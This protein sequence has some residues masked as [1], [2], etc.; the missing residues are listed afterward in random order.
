MRKIQKTDAE[1]KQ[2]LSPC[3]FYVK[4]QQTALKYGFKRKKDLRKISDFSPVGHIQDLE[5]PLAAIDLEDP[6]WPKECFTGQPA[7]VGPPDPRVDLDSYERVV[8][9]LL[10]RAGH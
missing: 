4:L 1:S 10:H 2:F 8:R 5:R 7:T 9:G 6:D 3:H